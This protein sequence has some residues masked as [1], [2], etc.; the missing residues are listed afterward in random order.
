MSTETTIGQQLSLKRGQNSK[1][2]AVEGSNLEKASGCKCSWKTTTGNSLQ[3]KTDPSTFEVLI[4]YQLG[5]SLPERVQVNWWCYRLTGI[6]KGGNNDLFTVKIKGI[7]D[8]HSLEKKGGSKV[9]SDIETN[10]P[11]EECCWVGGRNKAHQLTMVQLH[12]PQGH[13]QN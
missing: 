2:E 3:K 6:D 10:L 7:R 12:T 8:I 11:M 9:W 1:S 5:Q 4:E 13:T